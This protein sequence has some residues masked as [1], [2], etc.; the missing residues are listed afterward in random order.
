[1][2]FRS[3]ANALHPV[4]LSGTR[5][6]REGTPDAP[7]EIQI[8]LNRLEDARTL[9]GA[10]AN[11]ACGMHAMLVAHFA[12]V[13][14]YPLPLKSPPVSVDLVE[15]VLIDLSG[16]QPIDTTSTLYLC[17]DRSETLRD[18][19]KPESL[20]IMGTKRRWWR[21]SEERLARQLTRDGHRVL[22]I[23]VPQR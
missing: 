17:R 1:M 3:F 7:I 2:S 22:V 4:D 21:T 19:L 15:Q 16:Q 20:V 9:V 23:P 5:E 6:P 10:A 14:P 8:L 18:A 11:L 13:V 12:Q